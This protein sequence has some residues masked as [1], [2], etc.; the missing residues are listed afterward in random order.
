MR[1][2]FLS[3]THAC[4]EGAQSAMDF[5]RVSVDSERFV[6]LLECLASIS[7]RGQDAAQII[8]SFE[9]IGTY[10]HSSL[11]V[12][13]RLTVFALGEESVAKAISGFRKVRVNFQSLLIVRDRLVHLFL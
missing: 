5:R 8:M 6:K 10:T 9:V 7:N 13:Y 3:M 1:Y 12:R 2:R 11:I 4:Q